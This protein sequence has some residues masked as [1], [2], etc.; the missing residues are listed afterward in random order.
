VKPSRKNPLTMVAKFF[1]VACFIFHPDLLFPLNNRIW[2]VQQHPHHLFA[3]SVIMSEFK[4]GEKMTY[5]IWLLRILHIGGGV[6]WVGGSLLTM[7]FLGP[8]VGATGE[9]GQRVMGHLVNNL[10]LSARLSAAAGMSV[11]A[12]VILYW[13]D[14]QGLSSSWMKS[15]AGIGFTIGAI[16][17]LIGFVFGIMV[18]RMNKALAQLGAQIQGKPTAEQMTQLQTIQRQLAMYIKITGPALVLAVIFMSVA[19]Y[20]HF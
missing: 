9:A 16:F 17:G 7:F 3:F 10:K 6:F 1:I 14:S 4:K 11:L 12:G 2:T 18:G 13:I 15:G 8:T 19:R 5:F 20:F